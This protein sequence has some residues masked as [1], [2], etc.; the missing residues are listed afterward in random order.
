MRLKRIF[1][2]APFSLWRVIEVARRSHIRT[3]IVRVLAFGDQS[4]IGEL[5][6]LQGMREVV[7]LPAVLWPPSA[8]DP[9]HGKVCSPALHSH[10]GWGSLRHFFALW[11]ELRC[12]VCL[13]CGKQ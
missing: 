3:R 7:Q 2:L 12:R 4:R 6:A 13:P 5:T 8:A 1:T 9:H 11:Q 10:A